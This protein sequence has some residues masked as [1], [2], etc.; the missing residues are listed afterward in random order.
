MVALANQNL[1]ERLVSLF[2]DIHELEV[3]NLGIQIL[4]GDAHPDVELFPDVGLPEIPDAE[5]MHLKRV[6]VVRQVQEVR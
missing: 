2:E 3:Q 4:V 5:V 1:N 6:E